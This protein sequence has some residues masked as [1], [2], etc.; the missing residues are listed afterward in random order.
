MAWWIPPSSRPGTGRSRATV[1]PTASTTASWA[2]RMSAAEIGRAGR[3][4]RD[5]AHELRALAA[6]LIQAPVQDPLL[7][8][9]LGDAVAQQSARLVV[10]LV[11]TVTAWP[12]RVSCWAAASPAGPEP[13]TATR[14]PDDAPRAGRAPPTLRPR[15]GR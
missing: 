15:P 9:E 13:M 7:H 14:R 10:A 3:P 6:H 4:D 1:A 12:A 2:A 11:D 8:L 5:P